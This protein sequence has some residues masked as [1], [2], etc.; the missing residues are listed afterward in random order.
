MKLI[1]ENG[2]IWKDSKLENMMIVEKIDASDK[3]FSDKLDIVLIDF[4]LA[5]NFASGD[6]LDKFAGTLTKVC[7]LQSL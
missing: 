4:G 5:E 2:I 3:I 7:L 1:T 6:T